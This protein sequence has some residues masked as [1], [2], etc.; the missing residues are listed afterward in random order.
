MVLK[1]EDFRCRVCDVDFKCERSLHTHIKKHKM[2]IGEYYETFFPRTNLLTGE[3]LKFT[4]PEKY[5]STDFRDIRQMKKWLSM[6][7]KSEAAE[8]LTRILKDRVEKK[9]YEYAP[10]H[11]DLVTSK[12]PS[13]NWFIKSFGSYSKA[14]EIC[15]VKQRFNKPMPECFWQDYPQN[16]TILTDTREQKPISF[17]VKSEDQKLDFGDYALGG[18]NYNY[19]FIDRKSEGDFKGTFGAGAERFKRELERAREFGC[20][21]FVLC[22]SSISQIEN[23][24]YSGPKFQKVQLDR[25]FFN[26]RSIASEY[27][28]V[29]QILFAGGRRKMSDMIPR[30]L[31]NGPKIKNVDVQY[32]LDGENNGLD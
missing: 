26:M 7:S 3:V 9:G 12:L 1:P 11:I 13:I 17:S 31:Y 2:P 21:M 20:Y 30:I 28:D 23:N 24:N 29:C 18:E 19:I 5:F 4:N 22:E 15:G 25:V 10:C 6:Q 27:G 8:Y 32:F 14:C 16:L